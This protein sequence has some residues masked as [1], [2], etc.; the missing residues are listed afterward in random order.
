MEKG[1]DKMVE[2]GLKD[3]G[4]GAV[5]ILSGAVYL[6]A[7]NAIDSLVE[8]ELRSIGMRVL[9]ILDRL[10][11]VEEKPEETPPVEETKAVEEG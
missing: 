7:A 10:Q 5:K 1:R 8:D 4:Q 3:L 9:E 6:S 11:E 2:Q